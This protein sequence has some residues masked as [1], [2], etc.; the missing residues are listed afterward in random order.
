VTGARRARRGWIL[1]RV[2]GGL[3]LAPAVPGAALAAAGGDGGTPFDLPC[4]ADEVLV[5]VHGRAG[6]YVDQVQALCAR[7]ERGGWTGTPRRTATA[8]GASGT[9]F[10]QVCP[11]GQAVWSIAGRAASFVDQLQVICKE[12][13]PDG[14]V[15]D[16]GQLALPP[17]GGSGG[18]PYQLHCSGDPARGLQGR[19]GS[20]VDRIALPC[21]RPFV[22]DR[23]RPDPSRVAVALT[24][25]DVPYRMPAHRETVIAVRLI[26]LGRTLYAVRLS[27]ALDGPGAARAFVRPLAAEGSA[28]QTTGCAPQ[29]DDT[30]AFSCVVRFRDGLAPGARVSLPLGV[31]IDRTG[32]WTVRVAS[33]VARLQ[34]RP[35]PEAPPLPDAVRPRAE[36]GPGATRLGQAEIVEEAAHSF[37]VVQ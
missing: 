28:R 37:F 26:N 35:L 7:F 18:A 29:G 31:T 11:T 19:A 5:G 1:A 15:A 27:G 30:G 10:D 12:L 16:T 32:V 23:M 25:G 33:R 17:A 24:V 34:V 20:L 6:S 2:L 13:D 4:N 36:L 9:G 14:S 3:L 21:R 8:G 22:P